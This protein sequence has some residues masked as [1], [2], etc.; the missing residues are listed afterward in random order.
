MNGEEK[1]QKKL[2][3]ESNAVEYFE[4]DHE[5]VEGNHTLEI[6]F[7]N[8][9]PSDTVQ[10]N[11]GNINKDKLHD[12]VMSLTKDK[13]PKKVQPLTAVYEKFDFNNNS[14]KYSEEELLENSFKKPV[15]YGT[16]V[17]VVI[18]AIS[19]LLEILQSM[20]QMEN[21]HFAIV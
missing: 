3:V 5:F 11:D 4:F 8:K 12:L 21:I 1:L 2:S 13:T 15:I 19:M 18:A 7:L 14:I 16:L 20:I 9:L 10:D 17:G 6:N